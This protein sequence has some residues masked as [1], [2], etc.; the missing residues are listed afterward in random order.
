MA[1]TIFSVRIDEDIKSKFNELAKYL[2]INNKEFMEE[3]I[4]SY[5]LHKVSE[6]STINVQSDINELQH[7]TKRMIDIY[8]NL[9]DSI[10]TAE[11]EKEDK[12]R[13]LLDE[14]QK[15]ISNLE[16]NLQKEEKAKEELLNKIEE[17]NKEISIME[18]KSKKQEEVNTNFKTLKEM[19]EDKIK[20]L[21]NKL[22]DKSKEVKDLAN[23][24]IALNNSEEERKHLINLMNNYKEENEN[25]KYKFKKE[26]E[27]KKTIKNS[28]KEDYEKYIEII[29]EKEALEKNR[30]IFEIKENSQE[31]LFQV[32]KELNEK[33]IKLI[34]ENNIASNK[35]KELEE[36]IKK[37]T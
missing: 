14:K 6:E 26:E 18:E 15:E 16:E 4:S 34:E 30:A 35:I 27:E 25:L 32:Q 17:S 7:I 9:V 2:G 3:L 36:K 37:L 21:E 22:Q 33:I 29:K 24:R 12:Q 5:E 20:E 11:S 1:D 8:I 31:K 10:K 23:I 19:L 28:L 13:K